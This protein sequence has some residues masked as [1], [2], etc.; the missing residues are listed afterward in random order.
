[1]H[2]EPYGDRGILCTKLSAA[3]RRELIALLGRGLP[4]GVCEWV[5]GHDSLLLLGDLPRVCGYVEDVL[6]DALPEVMEEARGLQRKPRKIEVIYD[7]PD[8]DYVAEQSGVS[9]SEVI[10]IHSSGAYT[11]R[12][13]GFAPGFPY[14]DG[15]D[16]RLRIPRRSSP[17]SHIKPGTVA[18][19]GPH[20]GIYSVGSPG[21]WH[22]IGRTSE[23]LF[24]PEA[25]QP[26]VYS[27]S[28]V[29]A[30][31]PG[32]RVRFVAVEESTC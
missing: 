30:L 8:L 21:G 1:M 14:L 25:A 4:S 9:V 20:A 3:E 16:P 13:I 17:R 12:M 10:E 26:E 29:F 28:A 27:L 15:L 31:S 19:G 32:D 23:R 5:A 7:G 18:I 11:V 24:R 22:L 6:S 2:Y